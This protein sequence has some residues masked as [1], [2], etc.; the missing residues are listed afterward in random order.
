MA[1][2]EL[3]FSANNSLGRMHSAMVIL[4]EKKTGPFPVLYLLHGMTDDHT[5]WLRRSNIDRHVEEYPLIVVMP[6]TERGWY[7]DAL[8]DPSKR[9]ESYIIQDLIPFVDSTF[10]TVADGSGRAVAGLSMGGYGALRLG[11]RHP[12]MFRL[13]HGFSSGFD[14]GRGHRADQ[15]EM[16]L[17]YGDMPIGSDYDLHAVAKKLDKSK[18]PQIGFDTGVDDFVLDSNRSFDK[19]LTDLGIDH[20]YTEFPGN[21]NWDYWDEHIKLE[22]PDIATKLGIKTASKD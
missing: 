16:N 14:F 20:R 18:A 19:C 7:S 8:R 5:A 15:P 9:F 21:H 22:L 11:M 13:V 12:D 10:N 3:H 1:F 2:A 4:P 17:I 6:D